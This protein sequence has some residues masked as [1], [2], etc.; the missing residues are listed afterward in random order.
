MEVKIS[1][2]KTQLIK[3][4]VDHFNAKLGEQFFVER[5]VTLGDDGGAIIHGGD[6][7]G[8]TY[9]EAGS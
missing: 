3:L 8:G 9:R 1:L 7:P 5:H 4:L 6:V 2:S